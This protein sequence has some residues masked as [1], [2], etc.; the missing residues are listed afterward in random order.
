MAGTPTVLEEGYLSVEDA[1]DELNVSASTVR[2][3]LE[4]P[5]RVTELGAR[6]FGLRN[7]WGLR[8]ERVEDEARRHAVPRTKLRSDEPL[9]D[10][11]R[12]VLLMV[13]DRTSLQ[14]SRAQEHVGQTHEHVA[15]AQTHLELLFKELG[16]GPRNGA[17]GY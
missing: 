15:R 8:R 12:R 1:A 13:L 10:F 9:P 11:Q 2:R 7:T 16:M 4:D 3:W 6:K 17:A 14:I 5:G